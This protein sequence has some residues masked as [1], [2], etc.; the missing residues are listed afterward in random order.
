MAWIFN[1]EILVLGMGRSSLQAVVPFLVLAC[2]LILDG[3]SRHK[4]WCFQSKS[5]S[6]YLDLLRELREL[7]E[8]LPILVELSRRLLLSRRSRFLSFLSPFGFFSFFAF[9]ALLL[10]ETFWGMGAPT[11]AIGL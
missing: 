3:R 7:R 11:P 2:I 9:F 6:Y 5:A 10:P 4:P 8:L 1:T